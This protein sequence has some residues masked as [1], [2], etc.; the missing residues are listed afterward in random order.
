LWRGGREELPCLPKLP[1][2][3]RL[4]A[5][6]IERFLARSTVAGSAPTESTVL[7]Q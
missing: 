5:L 2:A 6:I 3:Q 1:L 4:T 7:A